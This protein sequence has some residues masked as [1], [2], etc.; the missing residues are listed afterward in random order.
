V[1]RMA[2]SRDI[3]SKIRTVPHWPKKGVMFR[4]ITTLIKDADGFRD[5]CDMLYE[6][7]K[8]RDI[9]V[10]AGIESRGFV[11]GSVLAY[12]MG[13]GF[14]LIRKPG[15]LPAE[16]FKQEFEKEYG[17]DSVEMH[18]DSINK[19]DR[20]LIVDDLLATGGTMEAACRLIEKAGGKVVGCAFVIDL[21]EL[22][23]KEKIGEYEIFKIVDFEGE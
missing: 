4:D 7:Y 10:I 19:G 21:P 22:K 13:K 23:G 15:K 6:H 18:I 1:T 8:N 5:A 2:K 12:K 17:K 9:D 16:T 11:F 14:V 20:V 3:K